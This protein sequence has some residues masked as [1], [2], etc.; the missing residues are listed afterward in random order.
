[1]NTATYSSI[2]EK[3]KILL[4]EA[5]GANNVSADPEKLEV[6]SHDEVSGEEYRHMPDL[7]VFP[8]TTEHVSKIMKICNEN[9]IPVTPR[10]AGTGLSGGAVPIMG[11]VVLSI[12]KMNRIIEMDKET[13]T[14][15]IEPGVVTDE[16][17]K[18]A[19][20]HG[21]L[22]AGDPCS[23]DA[24]FIGGNVAEN[25]GGNK[26]V[27]YGPT[28]SHV[29]GLEV[30]LPDGTVTTFGGKRVKDVTGLDFVSLMVGS[31]GTLAVITKITLKL[32]PMPAHIVDLLIPF[33]TVDEAIKFVPKMM[34]EAKLIP[35]AI[36]FMDN[37]SLKLTEKFLNSTLPYSE[38]GS[39]LIIELEGNS[40]ELLA[41]DYERIGD[42]CFENGALEVYVADNK[43]TRDK[44]WKARKAI[45]EAVSSFYP[46]FCMEDVVVPIN[47]IPQLMNF[48]EELEKETGLE[49][50][51]FGH[52]GDGNMHVTFLN[53]GR[54]KEEW[55]EKTNYALKK[56]YKKTIELG[57]TL[58]G[59]H[60]I[61]LK[62]K[63]YISIALPEEQIELIK[64][65]KL[66]FDPNNILNPGKIV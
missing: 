15:T 52:A 21:L 8:E 11:G 27:K 32:T 44:I 63:K 33:K 3:I 14:I 19:K 59:E 9:R 46:E 7:V 36:E 26:V 4:E 37:S 53:A 40:K 17:Q 12:E 42:L 57:G 25:A 56:L 10:G 20:E 22:Y 6:Y 28:G 41:D 50:I 43:N 24:S 35:T 49:T 39:H 30:V 31:E 16:I 23:S 55:D 60:G 65:V 64:R 58:S 2:D 38:A 62:R 1:M 51:N 61:G 66:A 34:I 54:T 18:M 45:A 48:V 5:I 29:M 47:K 13:L